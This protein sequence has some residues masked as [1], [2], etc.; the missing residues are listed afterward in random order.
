MSSHRNMTI[1]SS[2]LSLE[3]GKIFL[4]KVNS[5]SD[6]ALLGFTLS[7]LFTTSEI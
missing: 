4:E 6:T 3:S 1:Q 5:V 7:H 2:A